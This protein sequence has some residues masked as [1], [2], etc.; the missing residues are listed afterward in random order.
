ML[1]SF[2]ITVPT[3]SVGLVM[4]NFKKKLN[5]KPNQIPF[6]PSTLLSDTNSDINFIPKM[7]TNSAKSYQILRPILCMSS[8][9]LKR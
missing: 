7:E 3:R 6:V 4:L 2:T 8:R 1:Q 5:Q 9:Q